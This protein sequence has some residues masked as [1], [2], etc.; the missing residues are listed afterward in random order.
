MTGIMYNYLIASFFRGEFWFFLIKWWSWLSK[1]KKF[2]LWCVRKSFQATGIVSIDCIYLNLQFHLKLYS[3][4]M[5]SPT[6]KTSIDMKK[7]FRKV[8][9]VLA[10]HMKWKS[11]LFLSIYLWN[12]RNCGSVVDVNFF[13]DGKP[14][15][16][17]KSL[18]NP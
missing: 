12:Q 2:P 17:I 5:I 7:R 4:L 8:Y 9:I 10:K 6:F 18:L 3:G 15:P 16:K 13:V 11:L 1:L 14:L